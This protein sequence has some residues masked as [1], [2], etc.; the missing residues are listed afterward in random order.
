MFT[1]TFLFIV[2]AS[3]FV[4]TMP[5]KSFS[6]MPGQ[7]SSQERI[8]KVNNFTEN[9]K[10]VDLQVAH[11]GRRV[12]LTLRN[13]HSK[14]ITAFTISPGGPFYTTELIGTD[15]VIAPGTERVEEYL[16][17][18]TPEPVIKIQAVVFDDKSSEGNPEFIKKITEARLGEK[19]QLNLI[20]PLLESILDAPDAQLGR[21]IETNQSRILQ[22]QDMQ[23][24]GSFEF[25]AALKNTKGLVLHHLEELKQVWQEDGADRFRQ[26]LLIVKERYRKKISIL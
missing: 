4:S 6:R 13:E 5:S 17:P 10:V 22:L 2:G 21:A 15:N 12:R 24:S 1:I 14:A 16:L 7:A 11:D 19:T 23:E 20:V 3:L 25:R 26:Y 18:Q 9:L 8:I